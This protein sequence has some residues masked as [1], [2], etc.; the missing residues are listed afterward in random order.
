[1]VLKGE[2]TGREDLAI[3]GEVEGTLHLAGARVTVGP[4]GRV[5]AY[6]FAREIVVQGKLSGDLRADERIEI[7]RSGSLEGS[8]AAKRIAVEEGAT[9]AGLVE[10]LR[11]GE[12]ARSADS[13]GTSRA[14]IS[15]ATWPTAERSPVRVDEKKTEAVRRDE[16]VIARD[17]STP[18]S[19]N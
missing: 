1:L 10:V 2:I 12:V 8:A 18:E 4:A 19:L 3:D 11:P 15:R 17:P 14:G 13:G 5:R 9:I 6:I 16:P 7:G